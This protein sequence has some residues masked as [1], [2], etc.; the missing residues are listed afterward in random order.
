M[1]EDRLL[2]WKL[3][4]GSRDALSRIYE[5]YRD[6]LLRIAA[7]L[8][9]ETNAA[10]DIVHDVF[11]AF[12]RS[13]GQFQLTGSLRGYL[14]KCVANKA[15][16]LNRAKFAHRTVNLDEIEPGAANFKR[17]EQ[18]IIDNEEF[19]QLND[20]MMQLPYEQKEAVVLHIQGRMKFREIAKMQE[21]SI[22]T[23][24]SRYRYGLNKLRSVLNGEVTK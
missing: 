20:A 24:L 16:N 21:T 13:S 14:A 4:R 9:N 10:E 15:R 2:I 7:G 17:P 5:K 3:N 6:D 12:V 11:V 22:Q 8:L 18:W 1:I 19:R 23:T